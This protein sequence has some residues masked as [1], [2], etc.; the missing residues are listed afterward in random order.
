M[1]DKVP[2]VSSE[3]TFGFSVVFRGMCIFFR[4]ETLIGGI[5]MSWVA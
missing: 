5:L 4:Q 3:G 1:Q 2:S